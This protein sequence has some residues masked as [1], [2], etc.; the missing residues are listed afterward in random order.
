MIDNAY[1]VLFYKALAQHNA[2]EAT[3][4]LQYIS[5]EH[6]PECT[7]LLESLKLYLSKTDAD[8]DA[9]P[10]MLSEEP[11]ISL[12]D[13]PTVVEVRLP[14]PLKKQSPLPQKIEDLATM[15]AKH[16]MQ[17]QSLH[18]T[19][20]HQYYQY[21]LAVE[22]QEQ[23]K[24]INVAKHNIIPFITNKYHYFAHHSRFPID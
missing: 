17:P 16:Q 14:K 4:S 9:A 5:P 2:K 13:I 19:I 21:I 18:P 11:E 12:T 1:L 15:I 10:A 8:H 20:L 6:K 23:I 22:L 24:S 7:A 3:K